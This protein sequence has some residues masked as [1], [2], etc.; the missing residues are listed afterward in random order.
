MM[1]NV[2]LEIVDPDKVNFAV[3]VYLNGLVTD[4]I[5]FELE[6]YFNRMIRN[7]AKDNNVS[8]TNKLVKDLINHCFEDAVNMPSHAV[9]YEFIDEGIAYNLGI[10]ELET[11][12]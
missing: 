2:W 11:N 12:G 4:E 7:V 3:S 1:T 9:P 10:R 6:T 5:L 8:I